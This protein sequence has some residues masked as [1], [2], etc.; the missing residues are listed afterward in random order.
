MTTRFRFFFFIFCV[1]VFLIS[2]PLLLLYTMG[3]RFNWQH[4]QIEKVGVLILD[5]QPSH[6]ELWLNDT[7]LP[8]RRPLRLADLRPNNYQIR[9]IANGYFP[10]QKTIEI[11]SQESLLFYDIALF[12]KFTTLFSD[13]GELRALALSPNKKE[14]TFL[15]GRSLWLE[16]VDG[17]GKQTLLANGLPIDE[18]VKI[19][20]SPDDNQILIGFGPMPQTRFWLIG[21]DKTSQELFNLTRQTM[22]ESVFWGRDSSTLY[23]LSNNSLLEINTESKTNRV[24]MEGIASG[25]WLDSDLYIIKNISGKSIVY[26]YQP[27]NILRPLNEVATLPFGYYSMSSARNN[28]LTILDENGKNIFLADLDDKKQP[29]LRLDG[30][31]AIWGE[32]DKNNFLYYHDGAE[33]SLFNPADKKTALLLRYSGGVK[34]VLPLPNLPYFI[35]QLNQDLNIAELDDRD[36]RQI[37]T[38]SSDIEVRDWFLDQPVKQVIGLAKQS[39]G[40]CVS[41]LELR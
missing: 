33:I 5:A 6:A 12:K 16:P 18:P 24:I 29:L 14:I 26:K 38:L 36:T 37:F 39:E 30:N 8:A 3:W 9:A 20:W 10:W 19:T 23:A 2:A 7:K 11:K 31:D 34:K 27:L 15:D 28:L 1:S 13:C 21:K 32:G 17:G 41:N 4:K 25:A 22:H 40:W 35:F